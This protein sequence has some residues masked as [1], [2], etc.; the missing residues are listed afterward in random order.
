MPVIAVVIPTMC[1]VLSS[2]SVQWLWGYRFGYELLIVNGLLVFAALSAISV[3]PVQ[4]G[5]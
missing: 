4:A 1:Y 5:E 2:H 3:K